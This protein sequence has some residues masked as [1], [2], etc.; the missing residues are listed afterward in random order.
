MNDKHMLNEFIIKLLSNLHFYERWNE[1][2]HFDTSSQPFKCSPRGER[3][4]RGP[5]NF[6]LQP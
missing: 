5:G 4:K 3:V 2:S 1:S 6:M